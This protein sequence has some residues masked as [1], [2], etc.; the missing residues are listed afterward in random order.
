MNQYMEMLKKFKDYDEDILKQRTRYAEKDREA[1]KLGVSDWDLKFTFEI[2][3]N[4][5]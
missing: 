2:L 5:V 1:K 4:I 3:L